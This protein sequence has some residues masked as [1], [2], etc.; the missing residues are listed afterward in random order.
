MKF[1]WEPKDFD[2][3]TGNWGKLATKREEM[4]IVGG[5]NVTSLRDGHT[6]S[7]DSIE[8]MVESFN[9][10]EYIPVLAP[11]N[12]SVIIEKHIKNKFNYLKEN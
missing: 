1:I 5:K 4:V 7:Y 6:W 12:A 3:N 9:K 8:E 11:V 10:H 2:S